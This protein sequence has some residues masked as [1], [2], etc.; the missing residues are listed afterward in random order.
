MKFSIHTIALIWSWAHISRSLI[1]SHVQCD[2]F[3]AGE[4]EGLIISSLGPFTS[5]QWLSY[6]IFFFHWKQMEFKMNWWLVFQPDTFKDK[7]WKRSMMTGQM[8]MV[9]RLKVGDCRQY[10]CGQTVSN[11]RMVHQPTHLHYWHRRVTLIPTMQVQ[12]TSCKVYFMYFVNFLFREKLFLYGS[13]WFTICHFP[14]R[15]RVHKNLL[16]CCIEL[17]NVW[18]CVDVLRI[19]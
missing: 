17:Q 3:C 9:W 15:T 4:K 14:T 16:W 18:S 8:K 11:N 13:A 7:Q 6:G 12:W 2:V 1:L 5:L 10:Q 19:W